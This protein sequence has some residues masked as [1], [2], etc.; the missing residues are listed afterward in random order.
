MNHST[1]SQIG[2]SVHLRANN[3][4]MVKNKSDLETDKVPKKPN[5][6]A[7]KPPTGSSFT[8]PQR[9]LGPGTAPTV[10]PPQKVMKSKEEEDWETFLKRMEEQAARPAPALPTAFDDL[11]NLDDDEAILQAS[12][13]T[14]GTDSNSELAVHIPFQGANPV[15]ARVGNYLILRVAGAKA[16]YPD[17]K[18]YLLLNA[19]KNR[20]R[21]DVNLNWMK[22]YHF[23]TN[24]GQWYDGQIPQPSS[25]KNFTIR[26]YIMAWKERV[27]NQQAMLLA[28]IICRKVNEFRAKPEPEPNNNRSDTPL[29]VDEN[30]KLFWIE[31][32]VW[33]D[34]ISNSAALRRMSM[35]TNHEYSK[36]FFKNNRALVAQFF[37]PGT[38][39]M[40]TATIIGAP[41]DWMSPRGK[42]D[43]KSGRST[44]G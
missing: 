4:I 18:I 20:D 35:E 3:L 39:D 22:K 36:D 27:S 2:S 42:E 37:R 5:L 19:F 32:G 40:D 41:F 10:T 11:D 44:S 31:D 23:E 16:N 9:F 13:L 38:L 24:F 25:N 43:W 7:K 8:S 21:H 30:G 33:N 14:F 34:I 17:Y 1:I 6:D 15:F 12:G 28:K 29:E 26:L